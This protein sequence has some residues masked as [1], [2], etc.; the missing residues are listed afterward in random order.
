MN[1]LAAA[2]TISRRICDNGTEGHNVED[3]IGT[4]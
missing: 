2:D 3:D 1:G 4:K